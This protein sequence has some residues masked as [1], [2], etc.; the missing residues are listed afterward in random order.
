LSPDDPIFKEGPTLFSVRFFRK[1][2]GD[3][4]DLRAIVRAVRCP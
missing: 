2:K 3:M 4:K 1:S